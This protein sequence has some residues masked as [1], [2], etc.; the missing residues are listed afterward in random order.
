MKIPKATVTAVLYKSKTLA[1][2]EHPVM[3]RVCYNSKR[4]YKST[5]LSCPAKWWNAAKQEVR[6]RHPLAPNMNAIIGSELTAL[7]NK[8]LD[9]ERQG[10]PYSVQ[11]IFEASVRK[12]PP[13]KTLY[14]LFEE[15]IAYFRDTLQKHN[16][17]AGYQT[18]LH[19]VERFSQHR[20]VELFDVD[21]AWLGEFEEYLHARYADTSIKRFFSAL[22]ALMNY[23][24]QN[25]LLDANPFDRFRLSRRLD[26]RTAKRALATDELDSL[27]RYYLDTYYYKTRKRPDP[28]TMKRRC[29]RVPSCG[30]RG[31]ERQ[32]SY[33]AEQFALS[34]F[35]CSY[36]F[37]GLALVDLARLKWKDLVCVEIP[38]REK[39]DRDCAA[40]GPRYAEA[41]K[42]T[43]AFY[44]INFVRAKTLHPI[45]ILVEQRVAWPYM[46]PFARTA[47]GGRRR[48]RFSDLLRRRPPTPVR[49]HNLCQQRDKPRVA[50]CGEAHRPVAENHLLFG[51]SHLCVTP[52]SRRRAAAPDRPE[53]G[54]QPGGNRNLPQGVRHGQNHQRQQ[55]GLANSR[56]SPQRPENRRRLVN[57]HVNRVVM[58]GCNIININI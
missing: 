52:L 35:I 51:P 42:E 45:R 2:G 7:K 54:A 22:K 24:C 57:L 12:P 11:R 5:G 6:E 28:R 36:I 4:R 10:V 9:F 41:H 16:T 40:Y 15:R 43:V 50:A 1:S 37:Q 26:V 39:Y 44:E 46:K 58:R 17:A 29:W 21:G 53:H 23:A 34:M 32:T 49:T 27:I 48:L 3:I 30:C 13:R 31:E 47:K 25:G 56:S 18:L 8:V 20:T 38:D 19:I 55:T 33:D 14:D